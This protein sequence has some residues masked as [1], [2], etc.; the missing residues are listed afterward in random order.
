M[1]VQLKIAKKQKKNQIFLFKLRRRDEDSLHSLLAVSQVSAQ[2]IEKQKQIVH[3][4]QQMN[5]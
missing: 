1:I 5:E 4:K 2:A 3:P